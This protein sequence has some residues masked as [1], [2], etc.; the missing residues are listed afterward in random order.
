MS[1]ISRK[2]EVV[3]P[4]SFFLGTLPLSMNN[5][6]LYLFSL[7]LV[8]IDSLFIAISRMCLCFFFCFSHQF[9]PPK[10]EPSASKQRLKKRIE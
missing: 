1:D 8:S 6:K 5:S 7:I 2:L 3:C 4:L 10:H 9:V